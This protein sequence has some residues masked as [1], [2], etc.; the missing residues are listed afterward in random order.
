MICIGS[1]VMAYFFS[2]MMMSMQYGVMDAMLETVLSTN[3]GHVQ[4]LDTSYWE[5]RDMNLAINIDFEGID[6]TNIK[7][8]APRIEGGILASN[9]SISKASFFIC[10]E[11]DIEKDHSQLSTKIKEGRFITSDEKG[12]VVNKFLAENLGVGIG[13]SIVLFGYGYHMSSAVGLY[14]IVGISSIVM[15]NQGLIIIPLKEGISLFDTQDKFTNYLIYIDKPNEPELVKQAVVNQVKEERIAVNTWKELIPEVVKQVEFEKASN[16]I[17]GVILYII[18]GFGI[19]GTVIMMTQER[20]RE[21]GI[22]LSIGQNKRS[23]SIVFLLESLFLTSLGLIIGFILSFPILYFLYFNPI[24]LT[25]E[26]AKGYE[27]YGIEAVINMSLEPSIF[28]EQ[29]I[30]VFIISLLISLYPILK[31]RNLNIVKAIRD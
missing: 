4:V 28:I 1:I 3:V 14:P 26:M 12:V 13:D 20:S 23:L 11:P 19:L 15:Q 29:F 24:P 9:D 22:L 5:Q 7:A 2:S 17:I 18:V 21:F 30:F 31:I 27:V 8:I 6:T 10:V 16:K 25:G